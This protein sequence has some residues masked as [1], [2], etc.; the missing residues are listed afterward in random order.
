MTD[1]NKKLQGFKKDLPEWLQQVTHELAQVKGV[2]GV[3]LGGSRARGNAKPDSDFDIGIY[4]HSQDL[5]W[6]RMKSIAKEFDDHHEPHMAPPGEWGPWIN[7]GG[8]L[9]IQQRNVDFLLRD[10]DF[11]SKIISD[12]EKGLFSTNYQIGHPNAFYSYMLMGEAHLCV[13][14]QDPM[15]KLEALTSRTSP[16]PVTLQRAIVDKFSFEANFSLFLIKKMKDRDDPY[17]LSGLLFRL[18]SCLVQVLFAKNCCYFINEKGSIET[19]SQ[20]PH[21]PRNFL[22]RVHPVCSL[23]PPLDQRDQWL[24]ELEALV[25]EALT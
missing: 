15:K 21:S 12:C 5:D 13:H 17:Y 14:L 9:S 22:D 3:V 8:W 10:Y 11:V 2:A 4:Y 24:G 23:I 1:S 25:G 7:G 18:I 16:Y 20:L 19:A 6:E